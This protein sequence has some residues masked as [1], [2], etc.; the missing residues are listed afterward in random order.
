M[1]GQTPRA[2][3]GKGLT[4]SHEHCLQGLVRPGEHLCLKGLEDVCDTGVGSVNLG[5]FSVLMSNRIFPCSRCAD[6][7]VSGKHHLLA[8]V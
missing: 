2:D 6:S 5:T 3:R 7:N 4:W 1:D 8:I